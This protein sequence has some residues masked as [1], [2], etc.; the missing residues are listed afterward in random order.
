MIDCT[1][2][3]GQRDRAP[4]AGGE[5]HQHVQAEFVPLPAHQVGH[6]RLPD[7][8]FGSSFGLR[9]AA[10]AADFTGKLERWQEWG[11]VRFV[12]REVQQLAA[13]RGDEA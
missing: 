9:P 5:R 7:A 11:L 8:Q 3:H 2:R 13:P 6:A 4:G 10:F 12:N 1:L